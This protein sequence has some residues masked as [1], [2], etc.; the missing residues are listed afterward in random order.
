MAK[1]T[2]LPRWANSG[3]ALV[4]PSSGTKDVGHVVGARP[5]AQYENW[6]TE[7]VYEWILWIDPLLTSAGGLSALVNQHITVSGTGR[8]KHGDMTR[9]VPAVLGNPISNHTLVSDPPQGCYYQSSAAGDL[10]VGIPM[11]GG[12]RIKSVTLITQ[13]DSAA[14]CT[15]VIDHVPATGAGT[16]IGT[17]TITN[18]AAPFA[19]TVVD[20]T[21]TT[22]A[23]G[24]SVMIRFS[25]NAANFAVKS[26]MATFDYP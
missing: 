15:V 25:S 13:G 22:M 26:V 4:E 7:L 23:D 1:P 6:R 18:Q 20:V 19:A 16:Q 2:N 24:G 21:D 14:D 5:P 17:V 3:A 12:E 8:F 9:T 11:L 10:W